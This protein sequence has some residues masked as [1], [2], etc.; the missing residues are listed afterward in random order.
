VGGSGRYGRSAAEYST[1]VA[2]TPIGHFGDNPGSEPMRSPAVATPGA[3]LAPRAPALPRPVVGALF[4][5]GVLAAALAIPAIVA[6]GMGLALD[7]RVMPR[8]S[9]AGV[10][11][12]FLTAAEAEAALRAGLPDLTTGELTITL[13]GTASTTAFQ[14]L[15][16]DHDYAALVSAA[17]AVGRTGNT[18]TDGQVRLTTLVVGTR[19]ADAVYLDPTRLDRL[20]VDTAARAFTRPQDAAVVTTADGTYAVVPPHDGRRLHPDAIRA[21]LNA[22]LLIPRSGDAGVT[23]ESEPVP[24]QVTQ[25]QAAEAAAAARAMQAAPLQITDGT[26]AFT[27]GVAEIKAAIGFGMDEDQYA[28]ILDRGS[29]SGALDQLAAP[30]QRAPTNASFT[31][32]GDGPPT[33]VVPAI[34]GRTL[35]VAGTVDAIVAGLHRRGAGLVVPSVALS[36]RFVEPALSTAQAEALLPNLVN[37]SSWTTWYVSSDGNG[38]GANISIPAW[39]LDGR[40]IM[41]G[42]DL[43][44]WRDIGPVTFERGYTY[45]GAIIGGRSTGGVALAG[46]IC[47]TSTTLFNTA[48]R[49]G[50]EMGARMNHYYYIERYPT[51]LDATVFATDYFTQTM[52][53]TND[54]QSPLIIRS[55]AY[56]GMV[57]FDLWGLPLNR[58]VSFTNPIITNRTYA[59]ETYEYTSDLPAGTSRRVEYMHHGFDVTVTRIVTDGTTGEVIHQNTYDSSYKTVNGITLIGTG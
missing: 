29:L 26:D 2:F 13:D 31:W 9:V 12:G 47:S 59:V 15:G 58:V 25:R 21:A 5:A 20:V 32:N 49:A 36:G 10:G 16:R 54:T 45:G 14:S 57:R 46:G 50:L 51:G 28:V 24:V 44:F 37:L 40:V 33:G 6:A 7:G 1:E 17:M 11:I 27:L 34:R 23:L 38:Y 8:V 39:D 18:W 43:D 41:P 30:I 56:P 3:D 19:L 35:N 22:A 42:E 48:L 53:F 52:S 55:F 4:A